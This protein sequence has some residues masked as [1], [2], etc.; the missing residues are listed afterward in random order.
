MAAGDIAMAM[1]RDWEE[2]QRCWHCRIGKVTVKK[3]RIIFID[4]VAY[5]TKYPV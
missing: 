4:G 5:W 2:Q 1:L 3:R